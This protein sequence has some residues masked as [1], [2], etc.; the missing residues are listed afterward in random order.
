VTKKLRDFF[1][2]H[3]VFRTFLHGLDRKDERQVLSATRAHAFAAGDRVVR[4][5]TRDR[6]LFFVISGQFFGLDD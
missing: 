3:P 4:S 1:L 2:K 5:N 6:A